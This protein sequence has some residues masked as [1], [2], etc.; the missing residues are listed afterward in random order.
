MNTQAFTPEATQA[1]IQHEG[2]RSKIMT[3]EQ[4]AELIQPGFNVGMSGF[5]GS[6]YPKAVPLA[7]AAR[8]EAAHA[9]GK[10]FR[11]GL[12]TGASTAPELDGALAKAEGISMR[13]PY[14]SDPTVRNQINAGGM[15]YSDMHLS[16][17]APMAWAGFF[18]R[19][20]VAV[21]EVAGLTRSEERRVGKECRSRWS[22]Y[23]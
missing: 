8:M 18:G 7:L 10:P 3:A 21:I 13:L 22:P 6:G 1:R 9:A 11:V 17:V 23:H 5:T 14:Q 19:L 4:A 16:H 2:L 12:W 15:F 20:N